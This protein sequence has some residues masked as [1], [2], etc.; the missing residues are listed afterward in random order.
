MWSN[1]IWFHFSWFWASGERERGREI[2]CDCVI[3]RSPSSFLDRLF[4][5]LKRRIAN[6]WWK[7]WSIYWRPGD[8]SSEP[9]TNGPT[10]QS[11]LDSPVQQFSLSLIGSDNLSERQE[12]DFSPDHSGS[13]VQIKSRMDITKTHWLDLIWYFK[14]RLELECPQCI[15]FI[16]KQ[17][18]T[19]NEP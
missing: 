6:D 15:T 7:V 11:S 3:S 12:L 10:L 9:T 14:R 2:W 4:G 1:N 13:T 18:H 16:P 5:A 19:P 17:P 8:L